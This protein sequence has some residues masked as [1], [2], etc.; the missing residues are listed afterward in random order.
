MRRSIMSG[1]SNATLSR[2]ASTTRDGCALAAPVTRALECPVG[3][4]ARLAKWKAATAPHA[5]NSE[6]PTQS[7]FPSF[8]FVVELSRPKTIP[9]Y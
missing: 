9:Q 1:L 8:R 4:T 5:V 6:P 3:V 7:K 2:V